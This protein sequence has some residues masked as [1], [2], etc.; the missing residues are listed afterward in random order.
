MESSNKSSGFSTF[1]YTN[2][3]IPASFSPFVTDSSSYIDPLPVASRGKQKTDEVAAGSHHQRCLS[4]SLLMDE[5]PFWL[6]D[7][8]SESVTVAHKCHRRSASDSYAYLGAAVEQ[9]N[10]NEE[11][12]L[13]DLAARAPFDVSKLVYSSDETIHKA[14]HEPNGGGPLSGEKHNKEEPSMQNPE[15]P[16][17]KANGPQQ[18]SSTSKAEA[19][20]SKQ[21]SSHRSRVRKLQHIAELER[22]VQVMQVGESAMSSELEFLDQQNLILSMENRALRQR[23]ESLSHEYLIKRMEQEMLER[24]LGR[25]QA[26]YQLQRQQPVP[27]QHSKHRRTSKN[28][29]LVEEQN[30]NLSLKNN[31]ASSGR[32]GSVSRSVRIP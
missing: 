28:R 3:K 25:L 10:V 24:E 6:E 14:S 27:Q 5:E 31:E 16:F 12:D 29:D 32:V 17:G 30:F 9:L 18:K 21:Q 19:K 4:D 23:L 1:A 11:P 20:R 22:T 2:G 15:S 13:N 26:M 8:L 7:L